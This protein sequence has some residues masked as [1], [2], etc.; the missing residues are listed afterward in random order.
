VRGSRRNARRY[1]RSGKCNRYLGLRRRLQGLPRGE[2]AKLP[3][4][5]SQLHRKPLARGGTRFKDP[6][7]P[8][9]NLS[10]KGTHNYIG[11][12]PQ[13]EQQWVSQI[14]IGIDKIGLYTLSYNRYRIYTKDIAVAANNPPA[15]P[16]L[17]LSHNPIS[18]LSPP[19]NAQSSVNR[20]KT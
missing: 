11:I 19:P 10:V 16:K 8:T 7:Q 20:S 6:G 13:F 2:P 4:T 18:S 12:S 5:P 14:T 9:R 1:P 3:H 15:P 17:P